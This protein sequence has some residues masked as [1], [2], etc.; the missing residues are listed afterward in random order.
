[1]NLEK[2]IG[3]PYQENGRTWQGVDCWG[4]ARLYY[5]EELNIDLPDYSSLYTGSSDSNLSDIIDQQKE[6]WHKVT[7]PIK[8]DLCLFN[9]YGE[10]VHIGIYIG[11]N[12]F[13]H[14]RDGHDSV[15]E[16]LGS[17]QWSKRLEGTY[18]YVPGQPVQ[19]TGAPHPLKLN[20]I[21]EWA[22]AGSTIQEI[23]DQLQVKYNI[24][25]YLQTRLVVLIDGVAISRDSWATTVLK[26]GQQLTYRVLAQGRNATRLILTI[27][28][29]AVAFAVG[30]YV[31]GLQLAATIGKTGAAVAK[32]LAVAATMQAGMALV[33]KIAPVRLPG[34]SDNDP[35]QPNQLNLFNG[36]SNQAN[37]LGAIPV[38]LGKIRYTGLLGATPFIETHTST[39]ILN[40]LIIWGF[41]PLEID[42]KSISVGAVGLE[43]AFYDDT[44]EKVEL[45][46]TLYG[47]SSETQADIDR[48]NELY[49]SDIEQ[50]F[51]N[52]EL[53]NN[54]TA[55]N[56]WQEVEFIQE[57][58]RID[59]AFT[60]PEGMRTIKNRGDGAGSVSEASCS[61]EVQ[62]T[63]VGQSFSNTP[64]LNPGNGDSTVAAYSS[65]LSCSQ[66]S[67]SGNGYDTTTIPIYRWFDICIGPGGKIVEFAGAGTDNPDADPSPLL[68][69]L[70][71]EGSYS[72][73]L[74]INQTYTR[75]P[76]IP[77]G[78]IPIYRLCLL[79]NVG[80]LPERTVNFLQGQQGYFG[81]TLNTVN[82]TVPGMDEALTPV[83]TGSVK[84]TVSGG[85]YY[86]DTAPST[87]DPVVS[88]KF[89]TTPS[90]VPG[91]FKPGADKYWSQFLKDNAIWVSGAY[92]IDK[93]VQVTL[94][95]DGIYD[96]QVSGD[97]SIKLTF[98]NVVLFDI[99]ENAY[100]S[101]ATRSE[102]YKA[103]T[104]NLK[105][106]GTN[107]GGGA[108]AVA[109]KITY[110]ANSGL[111]IPKSPQSIFTIGS[112]AFAKRKDPFNYVYNIPDL[113]RAK[114]RVQVRRVNPEP[115]EIENPEYT[116]LNKVYLNN[117]ICFD[118]K[119]P[120][121]NLPRGRLAKTAIRV[122]ST[123]KANG[124]VDG[125]NALVQTKAYDWDRTN[126]EWVFRATNNPASLFLYVL[127]HP[128]NAY[129]IAD[130]E[131]PNLYQQVSSKVDLNTIIEWHNYCNPQVPTAN[132]PK[133]TY[134]SVLTSTQSVMDTLRDICAA[135][136]ASPIF[137]D[138]KWSVVIDK[139]RTTVVQH[140]TPHNSWGFEAVK[141]LPRLPHAF[142]VTIP[143]EE[144]AYQPRELYAY[145][146]GY[147]MYGTEPGKKAAE[148]FEELNLPGVTNVAQ[149][150]HLAQWHL[151]Q[152]K[153]RPET[154]TINTDFEYLVCNRGDLVKVSHDVPLWG[155]GSGRIKSITGNT[156]ILTEELALAAGSNYVIRIRTNSGSSV[157]LNVSSITQEGYYDT[158]TVIGTI[159]STVEA[160]NLFMF[161]TNQQE[162][163]NLIVLSIEPTGNMAAR[164][165]LT[166]Y[167][168]EIYTADLANDLLVFN[169]NITK[170]TTGIV[171]TTIVGLPIIN[172]ITS[173]RETSQQISTGIYQTTAL[174]NFSN[175]GDLS[176]SAERVQF[177][178]VRGDETFNST[179]PSAFYTVTK[180]T[181]NITF[182]GLETGVIY[183]VR[184]RYTNNA[185][186]VFGGWSPIKLF[187]AGTSGLEPVQPE[188][189]L[190]L[191][192]TYIV[193]KVSQ[194]FVRQTDFDVFEYRIYKDTGSEDF[195]EIE[196]NTTNN[197]KIIR[198]TAE[199]RFN[200]L[201]LPTP[202]IS[203]SGITYRVACRAVNR[204]NEY[205][206]QSALG[207]IVVKTIT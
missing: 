204:N 89:V 66:I 176:K 162:T 100:K 55:G 120:T 26:Q 101:T 82:E 28:V 29:I 7:N 142:R 95:K 109:A 149:A 70:Y 49:P 97:D 76:V 154:Y 40:L 203:A 11:E 124:Q 143:D 144:N 165:T 19:V 5:K 170:P 173:T 133:L 87:G 130:M 108:A 58:T 18:R 175:P 32:G 45:P 47:S 42:P 44:T 112:G 8:N 80:L 3:L 125:I 107:S 129:R 191:E 159:P 152:L 195:W 86:P 122:Q 61:I 53:L 92:Q 50:I 187:V 207:T 14:A 12:K 141:V 93:T 136:K 43:T 145:N 73:L 9:I 36:S 186:S 139:P 33:N 197:I 135:G 25:R 91:T 163:Q 56:P 96:F 160:D 4:L 193:A 113:P 155:I 184:A 181:G 147:S 179:N 63:K 119:L 157:T 78:Y 123:G 150:L 183:K 126:N 180:E 115:P 48:F 17:L 65:T 83:P 116:I 138:G 102:Y 206:A 134:N 35:G 30:D 171:E 169:P 205:S 128:A 117:A 104:Y 111:N 27:I 174:L 62:V 189:I 106:E 57:G 167:S 72:S 81:L 164:I 185:G 198:T 34:A 94:D 20:S 156:L 103:G 2:Y 105:I 99:K 1:M 182:T 148:I 131:Q 85:S 199:A 52:V 127:M 68:V 202:R 90:S 177:E 13:L 200:L 178:M 190:D 31:D 21:T 22:T 88:T 67:Y 151:A 59:I 168:P 194:N 77:A 172:S 51:K 24:G 16:S 98:N 64:A 158:I 38:V 153:L 166:D 132:N 54:P 23:V 41:G 146:Y 74:G 37:R 69:Q 84:V 46:R 60:F 192:S 114:Y 39:N 79:S 118:N 201:D 121:V 71:R 15:I 137:I 188:V 10:P 161:G 6:G 110:T 196:P 140:F 75:L